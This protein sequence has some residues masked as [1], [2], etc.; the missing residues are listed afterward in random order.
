MS[1]DPLHP[2]RCDDPAD[3]I[4]AFLHR[5]AV[6]RILLEHQLRDALPMLVIDLRRH[7]SNRALFELI[8][9]NALVDACLLLAASQ[10]PPRQILTIERSTTGWSCQLAFATSKGTRR[11]RAEHT[12]LAA[13]LLIAI[14][15]STIPVRYRT[16]S[17]TT[18]R[19][20]KP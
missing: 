6:S 8:D 14:V 15:R 18:N 16:S 7:P 20:S 5:I 17:T 9:H 11:T 19:T 2:T 13:A 10:T 1:S 12:D 3:T 4:T